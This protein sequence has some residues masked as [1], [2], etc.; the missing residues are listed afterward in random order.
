[1]RLFYALVASVIAYGAEIWGWKERKGL[2]KIQGRYL[3][4]CLKLDR[5][6]PAHIIMLETER[7]KIE[8]KAAT[9]AMKL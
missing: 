1:M 3:K 5:T 9:R 7:E 4:W 2:E 8:V 6:T